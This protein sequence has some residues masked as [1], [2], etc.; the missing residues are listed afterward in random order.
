MYFKLFS[1]SFKCASASN[2][3]DQWLDPT[4]GSSRS[5]PHAANYTLRPKGRGHRACQAPPPQSGG[6]PKARIRRQDIYSRIAERSRDTVQGIRIVSPYFEKGPRMH[7][8]PPA[9]ELQFLVGEEIGQICLDPWSLQF[10]FADSGQITVEGRIEHIDV[11]GL[12]H[13]FDCQTRAGEAL[14]LHQLLQDPISAINV[15]PLCLSLIFASGAILR[16]YSEL[17]SYECGTISGR[18]GIIVF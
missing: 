3:F 13:S 6:P 9:G 2:S 11:K 17:G 8:F 18:S 12:A 10:R 4:G 1:P 7:A 5:T 15:Q 14:Y 16:I